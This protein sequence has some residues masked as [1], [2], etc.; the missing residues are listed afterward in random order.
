[1]VRI[2]RLSHF[3][4]WVMVFALEEDSPDG[5]GDGFFFEPAVLWV[6]GLVL[7][8]II[9]VAA[10]A[11]IRLWRGTPA[12]NASP[13]RRPR[14]RTMRKDQIMAANIQGIGKRGSQEDSFG[15]TD[16]SDIAKG[17]FAVVADG[18]G[19]MSNGA[20]I[21]NITTSHMLHE[22]KSSP[23]LADPPAFLLS[24]VSN[25]QNAVRSFIT[26]Q[27]GNELSGSTVVAIIV[28]NNALYFLSVGDSRIYLLRGD[29][30]IQLNREHTCAAKL[31]EQ[32]ARGE[33]SL[34]E[35]KNDP[36]RNAL[37][38]YIGIDGRL[39]SDCNPKPIHIK[40]GDRV[41]LMSDGVFDT[42]EE[43]ELT[44]TAMTGNVFEAGA[45]I[46]FAINAKNKPNQ[47]N[48]TAILLA[49]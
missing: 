17:V 41:L 5:A 26:S 31:D 37:T 25:V 15:V 30:L 21:S 2:M 45:A 28:K 12:K 1:M 40:K 7:G 9:T 10:F 19:G 35:A 13:R 42:L 47:D 33:I 14:R 3:F 29:S 43:E 22:F 46:E 24:A 34:T 6:G 27:R 8:I 32:A 11:L 48:Y 16:I 18:M 4:F 49:F 44:R 36:Q 38:S 20:E 39:Q 23:P